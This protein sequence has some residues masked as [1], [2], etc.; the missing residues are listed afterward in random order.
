ML[1][2][3]Y[4]SIHQFQQLVELKDYRPATKKEYIRYVCKLAEH[5]QCDPATLSENQIRE[6]FL[7]LRQH[8]HY[9]HSPMKAAK[10]SLLCFFL[11][12]VKVRGWTVFQEVR[13]AEPEVLPI[14][15]ARAEVAALLAAVTE[16]RFR[17]CLRLMYHC[18]LRVGEAVGIEVRDVHGQETPPRL[19]LRNGKGGKDRYVPLAVAMVAEL[20]VWWR[21]H[22]NPVFL[23]PSP[24]RGWADR[25]LSLSQAMRR[26]IAPMSVSSVQMA[27]RLA[28]AASGINP[29]STTHSLRHSYATHLL[30]EG[31]S[32]RQISQYLGHESLDTTVVYTHL[33]ALSEAKTQA[34]LAALYP[35][36]NA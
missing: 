24:G 2:L 15:L 14:V 11:D 12:C 16:P 36:L 13:I 6:Y 1:K 20:R 31:V 22:R 34:A 18:G 7:F 35:P 27:Y 30:E 32:L 17:T 19:H 5:F 3:N 21:A 29:A 9:K 8:K 33:T 4:A 28:R 10:Y 26:S 25:T 23:F